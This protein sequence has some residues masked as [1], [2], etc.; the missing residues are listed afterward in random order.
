MRRSK[1][2]MT[3]VVIAGA[4]LGLTTAVVLWFG[5]LAVTELF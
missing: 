5:Y 2:D 4:L 3:A 1:R